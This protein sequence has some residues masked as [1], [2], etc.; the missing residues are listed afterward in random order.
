[1][2][3]AFFSFV[4]IS[5]LALAVDTRP[6]AMGKNDIVSGVSCTGRLV[7]GLGCPGVGDCDTHPVYDSNSD[8]PRTNTPIADFNCSTIPEGSGYCGN[9]TSKKNQWPSCQHVYPW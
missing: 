2:T 3:R 7:G 4:L 8:Y 1:M 6:V 5:V 9:F